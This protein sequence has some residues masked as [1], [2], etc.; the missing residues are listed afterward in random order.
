MSKIYYLSSFDPIVNSDF[1][2]IEDPCL[3]FPVLER[4][5]EFIFLPFGKEN[6]LSVRQEMIRSVYPSAVFA[7]PLETEEEFLSFVKALKADEFLVLEE[8]LL[9]LLIGENVNGF[10]EANKNILVLKE[11][12]IDHTSYCKMRYLGKDERSYTTSGSY[13][14]TCKPVLDV[15]SEK[16]M[17][18]MADVKERVSTHRFLHS[19]SVAK[20]AYA[21]AENNSLDSI[22]CYHAGLLHDIAKDF[23]REKAI[24]IMNET[25]KEYM[26]CPDFAIHQF[27]G[28]YLA[29]NTY[30]VPKD[31]ID[32]IQ[33]HCTRKA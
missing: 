23:D 7:S 18:F 17:Y 31:V 16:G 29:K 4:K 3:Y 28:A 13:L 15:F 11:I 24:A 8:A 19:L 10:L 20:T 2:F 26:P 12:H 22:L 33:F 9:K 25:Y 32:M 1:A 21:I 30:H 27:I 5:S 6:N 14:W